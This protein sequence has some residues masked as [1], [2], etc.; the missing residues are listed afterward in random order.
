MPAMRRAQD[1]Q[2]LAMHLLKCEEHEHCRYWVHSRTESGKRYLVDLLS[3][4]C[5]CLDF[6]TQPAHVKP[7]YVCKHLSSAAIL[8]WFKMRKQI[9]AAMPSAVREEGA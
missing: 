8:M 5:D 2:G 7:E 9:L 4:T 6:Q 1:F 3:M